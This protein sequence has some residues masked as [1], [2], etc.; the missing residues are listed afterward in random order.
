MYYGEVKKQMERQSKKCCPNTQCRDY[1][2]AL[3]VLSDG[4]LSCPSCD[5]CERIQ[6]IGAKRTTHL[7]GN[8][9]CKARTEY[10]GACVFCVIQKLIL[11]GKD[12][13]FQERGSAVVKFGEREV[14]VSPKIILHS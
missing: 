13:E 8:K 5:Y 11:Q 12:G 14:L 1:G 4:V 10:H 9:P 3:L 2:L 6:K 7:C